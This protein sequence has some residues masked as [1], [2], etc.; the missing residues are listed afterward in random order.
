M[1]RRPPRSTLFPYTTLFRSKLAKAAALLTEKNGDLAD[2]LTKDPNGQK[3]PGYLAKLGEYF[4]S[5]NNELLSEIDQ[6]GRN[7]EHIKD[8]VA[9]QQS[10]AKVSGVF[11]NLPAHQLVEDAIAMNIGA[12]ERHGVEVERDFH[13]VP[14]IRV[15]RHKVLQILINL[16]RN[17]KY[18]LDEVHH[19]DK[20][21]KISIVPGED[22]TVD[23]VVAD[24]G[25]GISPEN[26]TR[27]FVHGFT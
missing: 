6:L 13:A 21:I 27:I 19:T 14:L 22:R 2:Y 8:V 15:D 11:E 9:M 26:L 18:A 17:A 25:I 24:N 12:F 1:I 4:I 3:L 7:I 5:E 23:I 10:Y 20:R 16:I